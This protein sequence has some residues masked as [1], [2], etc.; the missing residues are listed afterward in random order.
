MHSAFLRYCRYSLR[1]TVTPGIVNENLTSSTN[2]LTKIYRCRFLIAY[3]AYKLLTVLYNIQHCYSNKLVFTNGSQSQS[4]VL[5]KTQF[6]LLK[7]GKSTVSLRTF[8][9]LVKVWNE[10]FLKPL[11]WA[12]RHDSQLS[13]IMLC[14]L[15]FN[16]EVCCWLVGIF[17]QLFYYTFQLQSYSHSCSWR[18]CQT[19]QQS[20]QSL[21]LTPLQ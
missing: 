12:K 3:N 7:L 17:K 20:V 16:S 2:D 14:V 11:R 5:T 1:N 15:H 10:F 9:P 21:V 8:F 19:F 13:T 4:G 18:T 6:L